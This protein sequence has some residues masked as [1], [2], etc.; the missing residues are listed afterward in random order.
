LQ[1]IEIGMSIF[2]V[3]RGGNSVLASFLNRG[4]EN[5]RH[6][7][8]QHPLRAVAIAAMCALEKGAS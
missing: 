7:R 1:K 3:G 6:A 8:M 4:T 2:T 5:V